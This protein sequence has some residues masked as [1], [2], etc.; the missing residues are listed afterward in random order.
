[1]G[2]YVAAIDFGTTKVV[3]LVGEKSAGGVKIVGFSEAPSS[4]IKHGEVIN[5]QKVMDSLKP[6]I[7]EVGKQVEDLGYKLNEVYVGISGQNVHSKTSTLRRLR[8]NPDELILESELTGMLEEMYHSSVEQNEK[9]LH[10]IPQSYN[11]DENINVP[12]KD[13][14]GMV[15]KEV[16]GYYRLI[17]GRSNPAKFIESVLKKS[18]LQVKKMILNP[19][20]SAEAVLSEDEKEIGAA[21]IDIGG[22]TT[23]VLI[24]KD[25]TVRHT[26]IIP[27][28]GNSIT[29]DIRQECEVSFH[30]A[31]L[32]KIK[33]GSCLS[34]FAPDKVISIPNKGIEI[35]YKKLYKVIEARISEIL[36]TVAYE[37]EQSGYKEKLMGGIVIT[38]A[39][40]ELKHLEKIANVITGM[41]IRIAAPE[42]P[43][44]M[45]TSL[46]SV[47]TPSSATAAGLIISGFEDKEKNEQTETKVEEDITERD[48]F[49]NPVNNNDA[50]SSPKK[51]RSFREK[52]KQL[53]EKAKNDLFSNDN[54]A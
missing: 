9:V 3:T 25:H 1:M 19:I 52:F 13:V 38:G 28:G 37:I 12:H 31:E 32:L 24:I 47:F 27:F 53:T 36:A 8:S 49:G 21:V 17:V 48:L 4:G 15:G 5:I 23:D 35:A 16:E 40:C 29:E 11:I 20:A 41:K 22:G 46:E 45:S 2:N 42:K 34:E 51:K 50:S 10:V 6:C 44:L 14:E 43:V 7:D 39:S 54:E 30:D 33:H 26:A 18:G